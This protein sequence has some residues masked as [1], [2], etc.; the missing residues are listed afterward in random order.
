MVLLIM[1]LMMSPKS[2]NMA[3]NGKEVYREGRKEVLREGRKEVLREG[4]KE[5]IRGEMIEG[6]IK[7]EDELYIFISGNSSSESA[8]LSTGGA[9]CNSVLIGFMGGIASCFISSSVRSIS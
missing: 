1:M 9:L 5:E 4:R 3:E 7:E 6:I 2:D 8:S